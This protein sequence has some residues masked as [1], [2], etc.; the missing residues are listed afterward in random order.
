MAGNPVETEQ[1]GSAMNPPIQRVASHLIQKVVE[2]GADF[3]LNT[4]R[5]SRYCHPKTGSIYKGCSLGGAGRSLLN[6]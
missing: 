2:F 4:E 3:P 1:C 6:L 5:Y